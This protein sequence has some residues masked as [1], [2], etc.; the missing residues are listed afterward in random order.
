MIIYKWH[1]SISNRHQ[2]YPR[3]LDKWIYNLGFILLT[4]TLQYAV[5][6]V[7][8]YFTCILVKFQ[9][10]INFP[11]HLSLFHQPFSIIFHILPSASPTKVTF[12]PLIFSN[13]YLHVFPYGCLIINLVSSALSL[14][15]LDVVLFFLA[16]FRRKP[17]Y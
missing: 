1:C 4:D 12:S 6:A 10:H 5:T 16:G 8:S 3:I 17:S 9:C 2:L 7:P 13:L 11:A 15:I 14:H